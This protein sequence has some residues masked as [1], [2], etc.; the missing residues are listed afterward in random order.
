MSP[1]L[2]PS[3][4]LIP[5]LYSFSLG[6]AVGQGTHYPLTCGARVSGES[7]ECQGLK[8]YLRLAF[9]LFLGLRWGG[10]LVI[11]LGLGF[12]VLVP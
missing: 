9:R 8:F 4:L 10:G 6:T 2:Q 11:P 12:R 1:L 5:I 3:F 7:S